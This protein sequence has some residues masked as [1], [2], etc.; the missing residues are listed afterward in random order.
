MKNLYVYSYMH[1]PVEPN[2]LCTFVVVIDW[3]NQNI[4]ETEI[5]NEKRYV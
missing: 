2:A 4:L 5:A 3:I 1:L